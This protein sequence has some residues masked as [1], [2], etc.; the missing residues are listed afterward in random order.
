MVTNGCSTRVV[1]S[2]SVMFKAKL[3]LYLL[4]GHL[5]PSTGQ[6]THQT[7]W[8][9]TT[10]GKKVGGHLFNRNVSEEAKKEGVEMYKCTKLSKN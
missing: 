10:A 9:T 8:A 7:Q 3:V 1:V 2:A 6:D 5:W 4:V